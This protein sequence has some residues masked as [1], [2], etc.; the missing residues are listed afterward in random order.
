MEPGKMRIGAAAVLAM[1]PAI[2]HSAPQA[3]P[4]RVTSQQ[5]AQQWRDARR[6]ELMAE[7]AAVASELATLDIA[8]PPLASQDPTPGQSPAPAGIAKK[9]AALDSAGA[10][11]PDGRRTFGGLDF[12][13]GISFT[14]DLGTVDRISE[15]SLVNGIVRV[16][17]VNNGRARIMLESH[18]FFTP[19]GRPPLLPFLNNVP[20]PSS[21]NNDSTTVKGVKQWGWG[22]FVALQPGTDDVIEAIGMGLMIG[23]R[24]DETSTQSFNFGIGLVVDPNTR[25][26]GDGIVANRALPIG[27]TEVRYKEEL[28]KGILFLSSFSF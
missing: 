19:N 7:Q 21:G 3:G 12:G 11:P 1:L 26:L 5:L 13:V 9:A 10:A 25:V 24:R 23:F 17:D 2:A 28:Q 22:P 16:D 14:A 18:Y 8:S 4:A 20:D 6:A 27:E 15:A